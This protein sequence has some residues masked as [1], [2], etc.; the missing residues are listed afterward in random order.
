LGG[1]L[2]F[3]YSCSQTT[4]KQLISKEIN[5][6]EHEYV[7]MSP[8]P[9]IELATALY[10]DTQI[11]VFIKSRMSVSVTQVGIYS[12][13]LERGCHMPTAFHHRV[14]GLDE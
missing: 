5:N 7:N 1:E 8:P 2:I 6:A 14:G 11:P 10:A 4:K 3:I 13:I 12:T 9:I